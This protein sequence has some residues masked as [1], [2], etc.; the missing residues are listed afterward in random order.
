MGLA[1]S[2]SQAKGVDRVGVNKEMNQNANISINSKHSKNN[3]LEGRNAVKQFENISGRSKEKNPAVLQPTP[4]LPET[5]AKPHIMLKRIPKKTSKSIENDGKSGKIEEIAQKAKKGAESP[6]KRKNIETNSTKPI[7]PS[8]M[9]MS[10]IDHSKTS[11]KNSSSNAGISNNEKKE[12][13]KSSHGVST[14]AAIVNRDE[15]PVKNSSDE[16]GIFQAERIIEDRKIGSRREY[17]IKWKGFSD[18]HNTW[19]NEKNILDPYFLRKYLCRKYIKILAATP[20]ACEPASVTSRAVRALKK[21]V[22]IMET[23]PEELNTSHRTCP[24][25]LRVI[26]ETKKIGGHIRCHMSEPNYTELKELTKV[27]VLDWFQ[28]DDEEE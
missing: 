2:N 3:E 19:E 9:K 8:N 13:D 4:T 6:R 23:N 27:V 28:E 1:L 22:H 20:E 16:G 15:S 11:N 25:C 7:T 21:G 18:S 10:G 24:I 26:K 14:D 12:N 5:S 17:L